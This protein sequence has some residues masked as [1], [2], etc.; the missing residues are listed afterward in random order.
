[1]RI[2]KNFEMMLSIL[3][4]S[5]LSIGLFE[6][7]RGQETGT[8]YYV[9][10]GQRIELAVSQKYMALKV[11]P[12]ID[13]AGVQSLKATIDSGAV[14]IVR[15]SP[16]LEKYGIVLVE[17]GEG[18][19]PSSFKAAM[20][21]M[22][23]KEEVESPNPVY[24]IGDVDQVLTNEFIIQFTPDA[25]EESINRS[26]SSRNAEIIEKHDKIA[27]RYTVRFPGKSAREALAISNQYHQDALV[28]FSEPNFIRIVPKRP[29][30]EEEGMEP[31]GALTPSPMVTPSD[32]LFSKQWY[33]NNTGAV[34]IADA[35]IDA[36]EAW[37][38]DKGSASII[39]AIIDE[40]VDTNHEDLQNK[41]VTPYDATDGD[42]NQQPKSWDGHGTACAG[43]AAA[44]TN[45]NKG[46]AGTGWKTKIMPVRIAYSN[47]DGGDWITSNSIIED[48]IRTAV[49]RG[50]KVLSNS[51]GGGYP[52]SA[53]NSA[54]DYAIT[55]NRVVVFAAGN[56]AGPVSYPAYLSSSKV[57]IT[58]SAT[59]EW[60]K[61]KT[62]TSADGEWWWG[63]NFGP[64]ISVA[65]PGVHIYTTDISGTAGY[66]NGNY[67]SKFN[68]TS[69][70]TPIVAGVAALLLSQNP[71]WS[72]TKVRNR[73]Q[74]TADD[75]GPPGF[76]NKFGHG[77][78]NACKALDGCMLPPPTSCATI[79]PVGPF[80]RPNIGQIMLYVA[81]LFS[82]IL[83]FF[84]VQAFRKFRRVFFDG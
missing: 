24:S 75:L 37:D 9:V 32:P 7:A 14:G 33:L 18:V 71:G 26:L 29:E 50:A 56:D 52:S 64:Q 80:A 21:I 79:S 72:P 25:S 12:A 38:I 41:I 2:C 54:I 30:I 82:T 16:V 70:A 17:I 20:D 61:L 81:L 77:R 46:V 4:A 44:I 67:F 27:N 63:S 22:S 51:W 31:E 39:V 6:N 45:N 28:E 5:I 49:D 83:L 73:L 19:G 62:K 10:D 57:I 34:G 76:D 58:V 69:S 1:M 68:G 11:A 3:L 53:I 74:T 8:D 84:I 60:D 65:A 23:A 36:P 78:V 55:N 43:I 42:N 59:N 47:Y 40:G 15:E 48:G 35:D 13:A 66:S